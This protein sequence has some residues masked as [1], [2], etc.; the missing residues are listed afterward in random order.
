M[1]ALRLGI[2]G[3]SDGN[4]HPYSWAA[5]FNGYDEI[6]MAKCPFHVIPEY[7][8]KQKFPED[9]I[10][11]ANVTHIWTQ[12]PIVS[13]NIARAS[14]IH[15]VVSDAKD[16]IGCVDAILLARD[17]FENHLGMSL[18]F[19]EAGLP[20]FI[21][22]P[23]DITL[24]GARRIL[25]HQQYEWQVYSCSSIKFASEFDKKKVDYNKLGDVK[26]IEAYVPKSWEKYGIHI[27]EPVLNLR[28]DWGSIKKIDN[29]GEGGINIVT[30]LW[31][32]GIYTVFKV[33]GN[34]KCPLSI[35]LFGTDGYQELIFENTYS[36]FKRSLLAFIEGIQKE[37]IIIPREQTLTAIEVLEKGRL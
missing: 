21:D 15:H 30:V 11:F 17:D 37:E 25:E 19:L 8:S 31:E 35:R 22:K 28:D 27:I 9:S 1:D 5:I 33:L 12:D 13:D 32:N 18:P 7:L 6:E 23:L 36:A 14:K 4:G 24:N 10:A 2:L 29:S 26:M 3:M 20:I 34:L 16:M